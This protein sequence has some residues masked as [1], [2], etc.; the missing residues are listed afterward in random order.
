MLLHINQSMISKSERWKYEILPQGESAAQ[1]EV[2][3][4]GSTT[5][6]KLS[7][8]RYEH[9]IFNNNRKY[10]VLKL[11]IFEQSVRTR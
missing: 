10:T 1:V 6:R 4:N 3:G 5:K 9:V 11:I 2:V 7:F 8:E